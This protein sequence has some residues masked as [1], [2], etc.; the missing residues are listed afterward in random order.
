MIDG[1]DEEVDSDDGEEDEGPLDSGRSSQLKVASRL[2]LRE[3]LQVIIV[4]WYS[5]KSEILKVSFKGKCNF[6][7]GC[8]F[9]SIAHH[10][11]TL[12]RV[13]YKMFTFF[14]T[15]ISQAPNIAQKKFSTRNESMDILFQKHKFKNFYDFCF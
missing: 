7:H 15:S 11:S 8:R 13:S 12:Y 4:L 3:V 1:R 5:K 6:L 2:F 9:L 14:K 10:N